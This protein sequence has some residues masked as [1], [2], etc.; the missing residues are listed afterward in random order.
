LH[1]IFIAV[2]LHGV[3][4]Q[5]ADAVYET[6]SGTWTRSFKSGV[7]ATFDVKSNMGNI[8]GGQWPGPF[9]PDTS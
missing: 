9:G 3:W 8:T 6:G 4:P 2:V 1:F 5:Q 7:K